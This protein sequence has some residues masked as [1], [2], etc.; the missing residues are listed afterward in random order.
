MSTT[1]AS[2]LTADPATGASPSLTSSTSVDEAAEAS[3]S[4]QTKAPSR[5]GK[6]RA[7]EK[8]TEITKAA[9]KLR[10]NPAGV[11]LLSPSLHKQLFPGRALP[12]APSHLV[13]LSRTHLA[14][15]GL[16]PE[17]AATL[18]EINMDLPPLRG[19]NIRDHFTALGKSEAEP[20]LSLANRFVETTL[21]PM[22]E[23]WATEWPGWTKYNA[24][25]TVDAVSDLG[26]EQIVSFDVETLYKI[27]PYPVMATAATPTHWYS[28]LCPTIFEEPPEETAP[29]R[30]RWDKTVDPGRPNSLI[31]MFEQ[32]GTARIVI[33]HNVGYDRARIKDEYNLEN[34]S[35]RFLD[36][37]SLHVATR[38]ITSVQRPAWM[39]H[40][41]S[42]RQQRDD[43]KGIREATMELLRE[44]RP[45][46]AEILDNMPEEPEEEPPVPEE[47]EDGTGPKWEDVTSMNSLKEV[48]ALH[49]G[50]RMDKSVRDRFSDDTITHAS[51]LRPELFDL[52]QYCADDVKITHD[53]YK[54]VFPLFLASCPHPASFAG[55]LA[56]G[57]AILPVNEAWKE[58]LKNA[59]EMY[60]Q[61]QT[62]VA[63]N[64]RSL[65]EKLR[66]DGPT[67]GDVWHQQLDWKPKKA[68]WL[69][70]GPDAP[71]AAVNAVQAA[72]G[73][74]KGD[75][76]ASQI[77]PAL[78]EQK[79]P[80]EDTS[81]EAEIENASTTD[82]P[83]SPRWFE[84][85]TEPGYQPA[86]KHAHIIPPLLLRMTF[87]G[88][89]VVYL[90]DDYWCF[91]VPKA[92]AEQFATEHGDPVMPGET[93]A[94]LMEGDAEKY[95][96]FRAAAVGKPRRKKLI[97]GPTKK[98][99]GKEISGADPDVL[100]RAFEEPDA[101]VEQIPKLAAEMKG[102]D[103]DNVW[104]AQLERLFPAESKHER[105]RAT[106]DI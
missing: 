12:Q 96:F 79:T 32:N 1:E 31:P 47:N 26:D 22:P 80:R 53:V 3:S 16:T 52:L 29:V 63:A 14:A 17:G 43:E 61:M 5:K 104:L 99:L 100:A 6:E 57:S 64:L 88:Y 73:L 54:K 59:E 78:V 13:D 95:A 89:P 102:L 66:L 98:M 91:R 68:R 23:A 50:L 67:P 90:R 42:K 93:D 70:E 21:P 33:G 4:S 40:R 15:N 58:Y 72:R 49:C 34:T 56:M 9:A 8:D 48:A 85:L 92:E 81:Q 46:W 84:T 77:A 10:R 106:A 94:W 19:S 71:Q 60:R 62:N 41:K 105:G 18:A 24:D 44:I 76:S 28:W 25:G 83:A 2:L 86:A 38:G 37:L 97:A 7:V 11:Q 27:S 101:G 39:K 74:Q 51:Q 35:T 45:E 36:T 103:S 55:A 87:R 75:E 65:A 69:D 30:P 20:Y 82:A